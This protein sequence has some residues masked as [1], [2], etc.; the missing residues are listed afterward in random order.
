MNGAD[1]AQRHRKPRVTQ[2]FLKN[3]CIRL[4]DGGERDNRGG[5]SSQDGAIGPDI[6]TA[7]SQGRHMASHRE[8]EKRKVPEFEKN[9]R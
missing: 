1:N 9:A 4:T 7:G 2:Q 5:I 3:L 6:P 8:R